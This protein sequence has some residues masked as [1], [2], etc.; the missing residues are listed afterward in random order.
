METPL[1]V[2]R[3][4]DKAKNFISYVVR[5]AQD[6]EVRIRLLYVQEAY[7][8]TIGQPP[9]S[10]AYTI[11]NLKEK[12]EEAAMELRGIV[13]EILEEMPGEVSIEYSTEIASTTGVI[14]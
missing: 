9:A 8:Y 12:E 11:D 2:V 13:R 14:D 1:S 4:T 5:L 3:E 7:E 10:E 6:L